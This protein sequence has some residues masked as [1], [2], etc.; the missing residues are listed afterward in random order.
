M[1]DSNV[2]PV[3]ISYADLCN[4][5]ADLKAK[6]EEGFGFAGLGLIL[7]SGIPNLVELREKL[8]PLGSVLASK[9]AEVKAKLE[10]ADTAYSVGWSHGKEKLKEGVF[11]VNKGSFYAN[12]QYDQP[13]SDAELQ[14]KYYQDY[15]P[16][17]WPKDDMPELESAFKNL[18][19]LMVS[20]G[21]LVAR[22]CDAYVSAK[23]GDAYTAG[24]LEKVVKTSRTAK[25]RLLH[26]FPVETNE[27]RTH[28]SWCTWHNDHSALTALCSAYFTPLTDTSKETPSP[29]PASGLYARTRTGQTV[30]IGI[31]KDHLAF[32]IGETS[33]ILTGAVLRA[34]PHAVQAPKYPESTS[35]QRDTFAVFM[36]PNHDLLLAPP[37]GI[38]PADVAVG[39]WRPGL[40]YSEFSKGTIEGYYDL[41]N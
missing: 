5:D 33:Q 11:D 15:H 16:N 30:K 41:E 3:V 23:L 27:E 9:P 38:A 34:T 17:V 2:K 8:L 18:G 22:H 14:K 21:E 32:Q 36:Q 37:T 29:D 28:D 4:P 35:V 25:G 20:V 7:V 1:A 31:P 12:P 39:A 13:T 40:T 26:Y 19:Q 24:T 10:L 6:I